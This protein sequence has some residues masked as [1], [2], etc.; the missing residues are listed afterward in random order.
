MK[1]TLFPSILILSTAAAMLVSCCKKEPVKPNPDPKPIYNI[2]V[3]YDF[4][5]NTNFISSSQRISMAKELVAHIKS[6]HNSTAHITLNTSALTDMFNNNNSPFADAALN[7][8]G[9]SLTEK[10]NNSSGVV[11]ELSGWFSDVASV[12]QSTIE[13]SDGQA[14]KVLGPVPTNSTAVRAA[15]LMD[16]NGF[17]FKELVEKSLMATVFYSEAMKIM[18]NIG[19]YDNAAVVAGKGTTM[20]HAWDEAFGYFGIPTAFPTVTTGLSYWGNYCNSVNA[21]IGSNT[22]IM[23]AFL[24]GRAAISNND[25]EARNIARDAVVSTWEKVAAA[26]LLAYL[27]QSKT[28]FSIDGQRNHNL[29]EA[30]GFIRAFRYNPS[31]TISDA[32]IDLLLNYVGNNLYKVSLTNIDAAINKL[33]VIFNLDASKL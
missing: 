26:K 1:S 17:E 30:Y 2:P 7:S 21:A 23:N 6:A 25:T 31:K 32:D 4:G 9:I 12:S 8:S 14:G 5:N 10:T 19:S 29:S 15:W 11:N 33:A 22:L 24:K 16:A 3:T 20:E 27:K 28:N 18:K 13:G